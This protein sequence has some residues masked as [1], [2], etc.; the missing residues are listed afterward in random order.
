M[1][2]V[3][4][5]D[6]LE[7]T[8]ASVSQYLNLG[9]GRDELLIDM[10]PEIE[11]YARETAK[12]I[13]KGCNV[14]GNSPDNPWEPICDICRKVYYNPKFSGYSEQQAQMNECKIFR[15]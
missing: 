14:D 10:F 6:L 4:V 5:A 3:D 7:I 9:R 8:Q 13:M 12:S 1:R 11:S 15:K 2:Q